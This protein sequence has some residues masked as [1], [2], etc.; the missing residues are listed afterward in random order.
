MKCARDQIELGFNYAPKGFGQRETLD[1]SFR[2]GGNEFFCERHPSTVSE[3]PFFRV[4]RCSERPRDGIRLSPIHLHLVARHSD[5]NPFL[6]NARIGRLHL[7][8]T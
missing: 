8:L 5:G 2:M 6:D 3:N 7:N 4:T 1:F